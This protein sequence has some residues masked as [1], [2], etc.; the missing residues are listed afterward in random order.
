ML[1]LFFGTVMPSWVQSCS[2]VMKVPVAGINCV[3][4]HVY[5]VMSCEWF[6]LYWGLNLIKQNI[7]NRFGKIYRV[8]FEKKLNTF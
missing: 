1:A 3:Q 5:E 2:E 8:W 6:D 4:N 7:S